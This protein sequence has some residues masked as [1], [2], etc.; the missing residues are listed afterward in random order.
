M[1]KCD[2]DKMKE[3]VVIPSSFKGIPVTFI[4]DMTLGEMEKLKSVVIPSSI[5]FISHYAFLN[6]DNLS[7][8]K[9]DPENRV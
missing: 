4:D 8:I 6:S 9:V 2:K 3:E 5:S 1:S 7:S